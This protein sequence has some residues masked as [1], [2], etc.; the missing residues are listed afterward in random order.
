[1]ETTEPVELD[2]LRFVSFGRYSGTNFENG[3]NEPAEDAAVVLVLNTTDRFLEL[4]TFTF[5]IDGV[6]AVFSVTNLPPRRGAW[7]LEKSALPVKS[8]ANFVLKGG[9]I[10]FCTAEEAADVTA[11]P[12][13]GTILIKNASQDAFSG[14]VYYKRLYS[15][16][17]FLGGIT[18]RAPVEELP[19]RSATEITAG[20]CNG[21]CEIVRIVPAS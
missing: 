1:M 15:D 8:G 19:A 4:G 13:E 16:G 3:S 11:Q 6:C 12:L 14:Y 7:L 10:S 17:N 2:G 21:D 5:E 9:T 20:H 18:F